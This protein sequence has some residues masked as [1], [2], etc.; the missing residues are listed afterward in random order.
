MIGSKHA[1]QR[2]PYG[3][4]GQAYGPKGQENIAQALAWARQHKGPDQQ[5]SCLHSVEQWV[6]ACPR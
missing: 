5:Q 2:S 4:K 6:A 3:P 1:A